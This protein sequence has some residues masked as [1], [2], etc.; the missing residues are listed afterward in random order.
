[1][2][3]YAEWVITQVKFKGGETSYNLNRVSQPSKLDREW[4]RAA[5]ARLGLDI[6]LGRTLSP[7][8]QLLIEEPE[9]SCTVLDTVNN[10][11]AAKQ[12]VNLNCDCDP[13]NIRKKRFT[14]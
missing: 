1:M 9:P 12:L 5:S 3:K 4:L 2:K 6:K 11:A 14:V 7:V 13:M 8:Q 10:L